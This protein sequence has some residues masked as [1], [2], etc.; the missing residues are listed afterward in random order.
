MTQ[1]GKT[2]FVHLGFDMFQNVVQERTQKIVNENYSWEADEGTV[3]IWIT[4]KT[5]SLR[6]CWYSLLFTDHSVC[7]ANGGW[8]FFSQGKNIYIY[9]VQ[10]WKTHFWL[11]AQ[12]SIKSLFLRHSL[13]HSNS[14]RRGDEI[15]GF[16][17]FFFVNLVCC[18]WTEIN[19]TKRRRLS[20]G[21]PIFS[22]SYSVTSFDSAYT[23]TKL[24]NNKAAL[25]FHS[26]RKVQKWTWK[27]LLVQP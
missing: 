8:Q 17:L 15:Y 19:S 6:L 14:L 4:N 10:W 7:I 26:E 12:T 2:I 22:V 16:F 23:P 13:F 5:S 25:L 20:Q 18:C 3:L 9:P 27:V 24:Q 1:R 21:P 11:F